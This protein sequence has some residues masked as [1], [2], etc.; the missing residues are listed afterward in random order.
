VKCECNSDG[1]VVL[2]LPGRRNCTEKRG[3]CTRIRASTDENAVR[4]RCGP[5]VDELPRFPPPVRKVHSPFVASDSHP[6]IILPLALTRDG[7]WKARVALWDLL[8]PS[9]CGVICFDAANSA[10]ASQPSDRPDDRTNEHTKKN[11]HRKRERERERE[12]ERRFNPRTCR[13]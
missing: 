12:R 3:S 9:S 11:K 1:Q 5:L 13:L 7:T 2:R 4:F 6:S 8:L 10:G